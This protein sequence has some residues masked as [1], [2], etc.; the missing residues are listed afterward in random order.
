MFFLFCNQPFRYQFRWYFCLIRTIFGPFWP[1][2][3]FCAGFFVNKNKPQARKLIKTARKCWKNKAHVSPPQQNSTSEPSEPRYFL[4]L[5]R[6][7]CSLCT[8][9]AYMCL[10]QAL[11]QTKSPA[12][13]MCLV[14]VSTSFFFLL[15]FSTPTNNTGILLF[16][17]LIDFCSFLSF[18][19]VSSLLQSFPTQ[20]HSFQ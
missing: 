15:F 3:R 16:F 7:I 14:T 6:E 19:F 10:M 12:C 17:F 18:P 2:K 8:L 9:P 20:S 5:G 11:L 4:Q 1:I 13:Q